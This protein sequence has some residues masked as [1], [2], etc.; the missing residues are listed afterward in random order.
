MNKKLHEWDADGDRCLKC[1]DKDWM[2]G[3]E[4]AGDAVLREQEPTHPSLEGWKEAAVA[5]EVCAS[6]HEKWAKGKDALYTTRHS[7]FIRHAENAR[8]IFQVAPMPASVPESCN[9]VERLQTL[10]AA[11]CAKANGYVI[12]SARAAEEIERLRGVLDKVGLSLNITRTEIE[13]V[14]W[15]DSGMA[16]GA[17]KPGE[18]I[19]KTRSQQMR[20]AGFTRRTPLPSDE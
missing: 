1:G 16:K 5:W 9:E 8:Q 7:D 2:A 12:S 13:C 3:P 20:E 10:N 4:C 19:P 17:Q 15:P 14:L 18:E 6:I 11:L